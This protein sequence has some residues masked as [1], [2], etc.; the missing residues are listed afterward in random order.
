MKT[1][2]HQCRYVLGNLILILGQQLRVLSTTTNF[3]D[4]AALEP[5]HEG[6]QVTSDDVS[7]IQ[8]DL[9]VV[10]KNELRQN[11]RKITEVAG[12][13]MAGQRLHH[14]LGVSAAQLREKRFHVE[15]QTST[16]I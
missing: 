7:L 1:N 12:V 10:E 3:I 11:V 14:R 13:R 6:E 9:R 16:G 2:K 4:F 15:T 5:G 8:S